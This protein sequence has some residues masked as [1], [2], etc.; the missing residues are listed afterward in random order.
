MSFA[1]AVSS[2]YTGPM[3]YF[4]LA[5]I[6]ALL[7][8]GW[9]AGSVRANGAA[10]ARVQALQREVRTVALMNAALH[11]QLGGVRQHQRLHA[12]EQEGAGE[13]NQS[14]TTRIGFREAYIERTE[15]QTERGIRRR[16][17]AFYVQKG[18]RSYSRVSLPEAIASYFP[19]NSSTGTTVRFWLKPIMA[20]AGKQD[21][22]AMS[23]QR[24]VD[25]YVDSVYIVC[26][27]TVT[28]N[29]DSGPRTL[30]E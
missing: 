5:G 20:S 6:A 10:A 30:C 14:T 25:R 22:R 15:E 29:A 12:A 28:E 27:R 7:G 3:T 16:V 8:I 18:N 1:C 11:D 17:I 19:D 24:V 26:A 23:L 9:C 13:T 2:N 4:I 21:P